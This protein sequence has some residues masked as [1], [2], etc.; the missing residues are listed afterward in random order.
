MA[1]T[2]VPAVALVWLWFAQ[3][4]PA[5]A[6]AAA[7]IAFAGAAHGWGRAV[8]RWLEDDHAPPA[9]AVGWGLACL[10][11]VGAARSAMALVGDG[12]TDAIMVIGLVLGVAWAIT[13]PRAPAAPT[14][15]SGGLTS[16]LLA[17]GFAALAIAAS[18]GT[19]ASSA[20]PG[21]NVPSGLVA[22]IADLGRAAGT[23]VRPVL[24]D[25]GWGFAV[26]LALALTAL[27]RHAT[28]T[29]VVTVVLLTSLPVDML[30]DTRWTGAAGAITIALTLSGRPRA[31]RV[32]AVALGVAGAM[33]VGASGA[34]AATALGVM[35]GATGWLC[36]RAM[37]DDDS[38]RAA[39]AGRLSPRAVPTLVAATVAVLAVVGVRSPVGHPSVSWQD[40]LDQQLD[41]A[42]ALMQA[43]RATIERR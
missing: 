24:A 32:W 21:P 28:V 33:T 6:V 15:D 23:A 12:G 3:P 11:I 43:R 34:P 1:M 26:T 8:G 29:R 22:L 10:L 41:A 4:T 14:A 2:T 7:T 30:G 19:G 17:T 37:A 42:A 35:L 38:A 27:P 36:C 39:L 9:L 25:A 16:A 20:G 13:A 18:T 40:R 31:W 5:G